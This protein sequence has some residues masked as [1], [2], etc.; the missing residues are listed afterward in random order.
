ME[1]EKNEIISLYVKNDEMQSAHIQ[2]LQQK[3]ALES[4]WI[5]QFKQLKECDG[6]SR[7]LLREM[8]DQN[9]ERIKQL[10]SIISKK[11]IAI[12]LLKEK[13]AILE[14]EQN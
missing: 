10:L 14:K 11:E 8:H 12:H 5:E 6:Q 4:K 2:L 1:R 3:L 9:M 7:T 13:V